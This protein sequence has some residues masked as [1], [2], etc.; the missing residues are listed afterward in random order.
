MSKK[1]RVGLIFGGR[2]GE[3]EV[4]VQSAGSIMRALDPEKYLVIPIGITKA[5]RWLTGVSPLALAAAKQ[6]EVKQ[7]EGTAVSAESP[8]ALGNPD[9]RILGD[10]ADRVDVVFPI[11]HGPFGED[12]TIQGLLELAGLP[13]VGGGVLGS[14]LG[15]DKV[16]M[17]RAFQQAGLPVGD[18]LAVLRKDLETKPEEIITTIER[19]LGYPCFIKPANLGSSVGISKAHN[20]EELKVSLAE[21]AA[22]DRKLV[23]EEFISGRE[24]ECSV[25]G[26]DEPTASLPGEIIPCA[27][28]YDY[29]AKYLL[30]DSKLTIPAELPEKVC[31]EVR[32]LAVRAFKAIDCAGLARVDFFVTHEGSRVLINE[33]NTIPGFTRIS[34]YPKMWEAS[35]VPYAKLLDRLIDLAFERHRDRERNRVS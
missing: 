19:C 3:H 24:I 32:D 13:Y 2:S 16:L 5:G 30:N 14:A 21:A 17:K 8:F 23:V 18:Y 29:E 10:L 11:L 28:F 12:G 22:Y 15:M 34:M 26:N 9:G 27:E 31:A 25:L 6:L 1:I 33:I 7:E 4:S 20:R 35:G